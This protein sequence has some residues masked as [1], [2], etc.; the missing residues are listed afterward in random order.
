MALLNITYLGCYRDY[1]APNR[2]LGFEQPIS[3][4]NTNEDCI[5]QCVES[6]YTMSGTEAG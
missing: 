1:A 6:N 2:M 3:W 5:K 4:I